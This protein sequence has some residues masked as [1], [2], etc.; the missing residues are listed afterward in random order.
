MAE[1]DNLVHEHLRHIRST[2]DRIDLTQQDHG[3]RLNRI[4]ATTASLRR[5]QAGDAESVAHLQAQFDRL[6]EELERIKRRLDL[7]E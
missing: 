2:V 3:H 4:E 7:V 5:E 1:F 6:R